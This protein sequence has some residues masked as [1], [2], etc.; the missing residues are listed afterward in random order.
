[1]S[2][3]AAGGPVPNA[4]WRPSDVSPDLS[5]SMT[6]ETLAAA[7]NAICT[8]YGVLPALLSPNTTGP[9]VREAQRHL[10]QWVVQ[11]CAALIA[12]EVSAKI[13]S[14]VSVDVLRPL[15]AYDAGGRA[16]ALNGIAQA[17][18]LAK[19]GGIEPSEI[20]QALALVDWKT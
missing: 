12:E 9:L 3:T 20:E 19:Q 7:R 14:K 15:Q 16:R 5:R 18:A 4:D 6:A 17:L 10:A 8:V 2:V 11:P 1:M 13:G